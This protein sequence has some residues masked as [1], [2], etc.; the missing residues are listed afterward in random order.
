LADSHYSS[1]GMD[2]LTVHDSPISKELLRGTHDHEDHA[3]GGLHLG[4]ST[5]RLRQLL[6]S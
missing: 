6:P 3:S 2:Y 4:F 5:P 1:G